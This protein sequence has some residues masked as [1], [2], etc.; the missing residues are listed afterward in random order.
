MAIYRLESAEEL[1]IPPTHQFG[2]LRGGR[3]GLLGCLAGDRGLGGVPR[4]GG[5]GQDRWLS[6]SKLPGLER[7]GIRPQHEYAAVQADFPLLPK[8]Y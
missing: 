2:A 3:R 6:L 8:D 4:R 7:G 5:S 1:L